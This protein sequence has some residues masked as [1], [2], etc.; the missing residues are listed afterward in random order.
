[1]S[2][3]RKINIDGTEI[4]V[5]GAMTLIQACEEAG[6]EIPR[7]CYHE[8]LSIAG[9]CRMCLVEVVGGPPKP[10]ASC[11]M[12][13]RD[14][15]PGPE[16]QAPVVKTN[17]PMV[18]KAREGVME[19]LLI[20]HPL[21]CPIC[22]Q[23]GECDLQDQ[24]MAY[25]VDFSRFREAKRA[26]DD[27]DLG[28]LVGTAMTRCISCT[29]CVRFTTE[30]AGITQM[31]QTGRGEDAEIT[32]YLNETLDS[33]L[34][35]N[36]ID[37]CPVGALTSKPYAFTARP[38]ELTK[39]ETI[40]VMDALGSNI[41][42]DTKGREVMRILPRNHDGVNE[43]WISDKT[44]FVW[45]G[46]RRQRLDKPYVRVDGKLRP[47]T[48]PEALDA[49]ATA[50]KGKKVAGLIGDLVPVE[51]AFALKQLVEGLGGSVECRTDNARLAIGNRSAY[52]GT[53][54]I[55]D[56]DAAQ[57]I[58]MVGTN[59]RDEAPVLNARIRKAW[60]KGAN[61]GLIGAAADLTY[62]Y[63]HI[64]TDRA[65]LDAA[66]ANAHDI[67]DKA[68]VI[69]V[70]QGALREADG[71]AVMAKVQE[72]AAKSGAKVLVLHT[73]AARVGAMDIGAVTEGGMA[74][75]IDGAEVIYNLGADEVEIDPG[76][77]VIYQG[78]HGD[79]GAHRADVIL[80]GAAYTEEN[81]LFV[82]T[83][84]RPQLTFRAGFAPGEAKENWAIL[85]ALSAELDAKLPYDSLAQLRQ[86]MVGEVPHLAKV[87]EVI[88]NEVVAL[89]GEPLGKADFLPAVKDFYLTNP[90]ARASQLM[91]ELSAAAKARKT[92]K[93]AA[94]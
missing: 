42:V 22:D 68:P 21:D 88:E 3:L 7:F 43:E 14:L 90:I 64:G 78:S 44:R 75:A 36:I 58:L 1:M 82:N 9:N 87:G 61:V 17:S 40:D 60:L 13:V 67:A 53:A 93:I 81:G 16:G 2:D 45:D 63:E 71:L 80:P 91:A 8:R 31:G 23:G 79:R 39:T 19:F 33:N 69:I 12:Q 18:K 11:A 50:M 83:E 85:R 5:D 35:G 56:I 28:P 52:V 70:G 48:W 10:A 84:G 4:E 54:A 46:L 94:E 76:A 86:A 74:A 59:P 32:S 6:V 34:Q 73:A 51:A 62:D 47:A 89:D 30:V 57:A 49:V 25:G 66:V 29:R 15:R 24:A 92:D 65:A 77:F 38:W 72:L 41:R 37:L 20:N 27:L 26:V 55:E